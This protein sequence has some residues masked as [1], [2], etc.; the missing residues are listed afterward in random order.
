MWRTTSLA[1]ETGLCLYR[2]VVGRVCASLALHCINS[3]YAESFV[4]DP[5]SSHH[6]I[7]VIVSPLTA[8]KY[9]CFGL[10]AGGEARRGGIVLRLLG[11]VVISHDL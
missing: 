3:E 9:R 4:S 7:T 5:S 10:K 11:N 8:F 6:S 1:A 2:P